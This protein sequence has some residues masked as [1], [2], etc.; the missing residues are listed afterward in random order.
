MEA[1]GQQRPAGSQ[2]SEGV[3]GRWAVAELASAPCLP[4]PGAQHLAVLSL[5][6]LQL[7]FLCLTPFA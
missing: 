2:K 1:G 3:L 7:A 5:P 6:S 4:E